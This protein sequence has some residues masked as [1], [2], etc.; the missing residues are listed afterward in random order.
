MERSGAAEQAALV[1]GRGWSKHRAPDYVLM[2]D[3]SPNSTADGKRG[4]ANEEQPSAVSNSREPVQARVAQ[5]QLTWSAPLLFLPARS[6]LLVLGQTL[7]A[8]YFWSRGYAW[9]WSTAGAWWTV[10]GSIADLG[11]LA[12]LVVLTRRENLRVRDLLGPVPSRLLL[13]G[14]GY[15]FLIAP[16]SAA[17]TFLASK[18]VYNVWQAPLPPGVLVARHLP[19]WGVLYSLILWPLLWATTEELTYNGYLAPRI[20]ALSR[21]EWLSFALVGFWWAAQHCFLPF[22]PDMRFLVYGLLSFTLGVLALLLLYQ[23]TQ[24]LRSVI[25]AHWILDVVA[26]AT[27]LSFRP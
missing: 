20:A 12:M 8:I 19:L 14:L 1:L 3:A 21:S 27:T 22:V 23:R 17:A 5:R 13:K 9:P 25:V 2:E 7:F 11:C 16:P 26:A 18:L 15:F 4:S 6:G 10:W 24:R